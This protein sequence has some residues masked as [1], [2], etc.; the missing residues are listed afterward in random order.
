MP[1]R[2]SRAETSPSCMT[3]APRQRRVLLVQRDA[4]RRTAAG[5]A[6]PCAGCAAR[7]TGLPSSVKPSAPASRSSAISV[8]ASPAR[9]RGDRGEEADRDARLAP[10]RLAQRAQDRRGVDRRVGVR[11]R[12]D[13]DE[14]AGGGRAGAGVE[15]LLV[16]LARACAGARAGRRSP[17]TGGG[18]RRR[19]PRRRPAPRGPGAPSSAISP[20]RTSTSSGA[21]MPGARVEHVGAADQQVGGRRVA[22]TSRASAPWTRG[23]IT[24]AAG[25]GWTRRARRGAARQQLVEHRHADDDAGRDLLADHRLRRVD[26]LGGELD[27]AVDRAG[28]H[29]HLAR[30][31]GGGR[32]S[33]SA[34]RT[35]A[36]RARSES[37]MRSFCIRSA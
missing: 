32:R 25:P 3:P 26:H 17:G 21:S 5:T 7:W 28:V 22:A 36:A 4:R 16:L 29:E 2:P 35:R 37:V 24:R 31:R 30:R 10:R 27:A 20:P 1:A 6:A 23:A 8:S 11:H 18:P 34:R 14:A 33:G 19:G 9:P 13:G 15:V 12:D